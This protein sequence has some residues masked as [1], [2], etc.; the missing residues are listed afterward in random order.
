MSPRNVAG[1]SAFCVR[2]RLPAGPLPS[3]FRSDGIGTGL[4][5]FVLT[6]FLHANR[7]PLR[8]KTLER[9]FSGDL[10]Q[11]MDDAGEIHATVTGLLEGRI[12][13]LGVRAKRRRG[14]GSLG[15]R[16]R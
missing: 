15:G 1:Q 11:M 3:H 14:A 16:L 13:F 4:W 7:Y 5:I 8:S 10:A 6:R 12:N 9:L 2:S